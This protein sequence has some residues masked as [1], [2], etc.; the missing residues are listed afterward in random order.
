VRAVG[1]THLLARG[2]RGPDERHVERPG[3]L[4]AGPYNAAKTAVTEEVPPLAQELDLGVI[5]ISPR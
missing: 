5:S 2:F 3:G 4:R 1:A